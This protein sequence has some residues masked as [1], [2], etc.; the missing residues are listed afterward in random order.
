[1]AT[2]GF[3]EDAVSAVT[4]IK[5][6]NF[7]MD[8]PDLIQPQMTQIHWQSEEWHSSPSPSLR[9]GSLHVNVSS[10]GEQRD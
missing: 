4:I 2:L 10:P 6:D 8:Q 9:H 5:H 1:M 3:R 7:Q